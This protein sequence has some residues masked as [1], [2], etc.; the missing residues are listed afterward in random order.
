MLASQSSQHNTHFQY[1][2]GGPVN[3][4]D[5]DE[6]VETCLTYNH[7]VNNCDLEDVLIRSLLLPG[8]DCIFD[9]RGIDAWYLFG[10]NYP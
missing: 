3:L 8:I 4:K 1:L 10:F 7:L 2:K 9:V 6:N 5:K